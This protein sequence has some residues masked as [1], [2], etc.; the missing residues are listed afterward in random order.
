M[1]ST[2]NKSKF[3]TKTFKTFKKSVRCFIPLQKRTIQGKIHFVTFS[4]NLLFVDF[5][6]KY[7]IE[8]FENELKLCIPN[9][10]SLKEKC[11]YI[12]TLSFIE[13]NIIVLRNFFL[14]KILIEKRKN[15]L[16][17]KIFS[18]VFFLQQ[19]RKSKQ[20]RYYI[21]GRILNR[22]K[23]GFAVGISGYVGFLPLS[24]GLL[25]NFGRITLFYILSIDLEKSILVVSQMK[26]NGILRRQLKKL[27]SR[28]INFDKNISIN[29]IR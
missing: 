18:F 20:K 13:F 1:I 9:D 27:G 17:F 15:N 6:F 11:N 22:I 28:F 3:I 19:K 5:G 14:N 29:S 26:I 21:K 12:K 25:K 7:E 8:S 10:L 23:G 24:H 16:D 2:L 4:N